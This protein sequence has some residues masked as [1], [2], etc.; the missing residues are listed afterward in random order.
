[1]RWLA[2]LII[3]VPCLAWS[4]P[5]ENLNDDEARKAESGQNVGYEAGFFLGNLLPNQIGGVTEITGLGGARG[6]Y[7]MGHN[8]F[9]EAALY[10]GN[11]SGAE[12]KSASASLRMDIPVE[13]LV[14]MAYL[15][16]DIVYYKG[17]GSSSAK[18]IFGGHVGGGI[19]ALIGG[20]TWFRADMKFGFSPGTSLFISFG[21][22]FRMPNGGSGGAD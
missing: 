4:Q 12:W 2:F 5:D 21:F 8:A 17:A 7:K 1:M 19:Q 22:V 6:G 10:T 18:V 13:T 20:I 16:P 9:A 15:G 3:F 11:G 14:G